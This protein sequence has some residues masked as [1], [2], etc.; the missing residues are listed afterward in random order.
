MKFSL[1]VTRRLLAALAVAAASALVSACS[2]PSVF[3]AL[4]D[5][6]AP[7]NDTTLTPDQVKQA[8]DS[9]ISDRNHLCSEAV[10]NATPGGTP[11]D[12]GA[13]AATGATPAAG[14]AAKPW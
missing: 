9:L 5:E 11:P 10:A 4:F 2:A 8:T 1:S 14:A 12:C 6:P 3:P 7:R 13:Q